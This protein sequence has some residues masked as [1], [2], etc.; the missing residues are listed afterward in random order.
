VRVGLYI[1]VPFCR[2]RCTYCDFNTYAGLLDLRRPYVRALLQELALHAARHPALRVQTLYFGGGTPS[3]LAPESVARLIEGARRHSGL[4]EDA[5]VT[6]EANPGTVDRAALRRLREAG[7]NR[8]SLGIQSASAKEL[9]LLGRIHG[10]EEALTAV[11]DARAAGFEN[12]SLDLI[13]A[14]PGQSLVAWSRTLEA[15]LALSPRHLSLYALKLE[16]GTPLADQVRCGVLPEPD[17]DLAADMYQLAAE[18]LQTAGFWQYEIS[19]WVQGVQPPPAVWALPPGGRTEEIGPWVAHHNL[20]YWRNRPWLG[21]GAGAHSWLSG[22]RWS[23]R[24][25]PRDYIAQLAERQL[26]IGE[27][28]PI[29]AALEMGETLMMGLRLAEGVADGEFHSRFD[30]HLEERYG[31]LI[32]RYVGWGLL[33]WCAER[34]RLTAAGRLLGNQVFGAFL[35]D[36]GD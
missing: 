19:N 31:A 8:L 9:A 5:E 14:L 6:L 26:P 15:A 34:L 16:P 20:I 17:P 1:H 30:V 22:Q 35:P 36:V 18:R 24:V 23:N 32:E 13:F 3:L 27:E 25:R 21:L 4:P 11:E 28:E 33:E 10:W 29:P 2:R 12:L 7:V